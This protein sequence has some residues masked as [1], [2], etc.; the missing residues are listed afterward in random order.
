MLQLADSSPDS[1]GWYDFD[2]NFEFDEPWVGK[3]VFYLHTPP[4][5][6][7]GYEYV[8]GRITR[9]AANSKRPDNVMPEEWQMIGP[10]ERA[11]LTKAWAPIKARIALGDFDVIVVSPPCHTHTY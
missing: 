9:V 7:G 5:E 1:G 2:P 8:E 6:R 4:S 3:T 10:N 11:R